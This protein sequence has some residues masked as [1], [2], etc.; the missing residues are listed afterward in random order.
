MVVDL[1]Y[2][3]EPGASLTEA[4]TGV[5]IAREMTNAINKAYG[6][7]RY[8]DL[9]SLKATDTATSINLFEISVSTDGATP[10]DDDKLVVSLSETRTGAD[11]AFGSFL[12]LS[13]IRTEDAV[14]AIQAQINEN[15]YELGLIGSEALAATNQ[16]ASLAAVANGNG[17]T[18]GNPD[19]SGRCCSRRDW[20]A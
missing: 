1:S 10:S 12:R 15:A 6:D 16:F 8:F 18:L 11:P 3:N 7:E 17:V 5:E 4:Y 13:E 2:L 14:D 19:R 20:C 9:S